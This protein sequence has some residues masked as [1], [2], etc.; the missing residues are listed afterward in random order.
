MFTLVSKSL[1]MFTTAAQARKY[2]TRANISPVQISE[3]AN[4]HGRMLGASVG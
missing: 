2:S 4:V 3:T 1:F